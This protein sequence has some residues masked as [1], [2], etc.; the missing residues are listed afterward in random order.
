MDENCAWKINFKRVVSGLTHI[1]N[2]VLKHGLFHGYHFNVHEND[3]GK[4]MYEVES[5]LRTGSTR[6]YPIQLWL[7]YLGG[8]MSLPWG[9]LWLTNSRVLAYGCGDDGMGETIPNFFSYTWISYKARHG[10]KYMFDCMT[11]HGEHA[12]GCLIILVLL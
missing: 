11:W 6:I 4:K 7:V 10:Y 2:R 1:I 5:V 9:I 8:L 3:F 12:C